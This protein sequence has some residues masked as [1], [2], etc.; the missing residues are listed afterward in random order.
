MLAHKHI[1]FFQF[2]ATEFTIH[3]CYNSRIFSLFVL[4]FSFINSSNCIYI[5]LKK[6]K[7]SFYHNSVGLKISCKLLF[8]KQLFGGFPGGPM[9]MTSPYNV[10]DAGSIL[11]GSKS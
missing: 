7:V 5:Y 6:L 10:G 1:F 8:K 11:H 2:N 3:F 9:V 4:V